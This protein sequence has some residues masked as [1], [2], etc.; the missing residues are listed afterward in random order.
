MDYGSLIRAV[1]SRYRNTLYYTDASA[2]QNML[3][4][5]PTCLIK[6]Y[7]LFPYKFEFRI[8]CEGFH[9]LKCLISVL[10]NRFKGKNFEYINSIDSHLCNVVSIAVTRVNSYTRDTGFP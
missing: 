9:W 7:G 2:Y 8:K 10:P 1:V 5:R 6:F 4:P 3:F